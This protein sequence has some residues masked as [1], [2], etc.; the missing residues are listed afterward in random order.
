MQQLSMSHLN[1]LPFI[2][3]LDERSELD[4]KEISGAIDPL[5][6]IASG[7]KES[8]FA[9]TTRIKQG[10]LTFEEP[11]NNLDQTKKLVL[12]MVIS[13]MQQYWTAE[14]IKRIIGLETQDVEEDEVTR[15][16]YEFK[17]KKS[18]LK[19][20]VLLDKTESPTIKAIKFREIGELIQMVPNYAG[21][22]L[23]VLVGQSDWE[24]K[25][26]ILESIEKIQLQEQ[27]SKREGVA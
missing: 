4:L 15:F 22:L 10:L 6:G 5:M 16:I 1:I 18:L 7:S 14:K 20:D 2:T 12:Q 26:E 8:G 17:N 27:I 21:A 3:N 24:S 23:P 9:A 13:N 11:L 25:D 19:Y